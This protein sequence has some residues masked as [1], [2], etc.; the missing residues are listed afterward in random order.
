M[1][2]LG[3]GWE[4]VFR[5]QEMTKLLCFYVREARVGERI[6][7]FFNTKIEVN[8]NTKIHYQLGLNFFQTSLDFKSLLFQ[9][10]STRN[11]RFLFGRCALHAWCF[12]EVLD[13]HFFFFQV[14]GKYP[15]NKQKN[16]PPPPALHCT[17][18]FH[19]LNPKVFVHL[20]WVDSKLVEKKTA[21]FNETFFSTLLD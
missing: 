16:C 19:W 2:K 18:Q 10:Y 12:L 3:V 15:Q 20:F 1:I 5:S 8:F 14:L 4:G 9:N 17:A 11:S 13:G 6:R 7:N 21:P